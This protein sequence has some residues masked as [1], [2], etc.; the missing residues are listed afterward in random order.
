MLTTV[1][2]TA[3]ELH[4]SHSSNKVIVGVFVVVVVVRVAVVNR[5][6]SRTSSQSASNL[7]KND[8]IYNASYYQ[9]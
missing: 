3:R 2:K 7:G 1:L 4:P 9:Y 5:N 6:R 8:L